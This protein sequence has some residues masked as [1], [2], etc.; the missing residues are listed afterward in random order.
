MS[1]GHR[2]DYGNAIMQKGGFCLGRTI[3]AISR[4]ASLESANK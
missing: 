1:T 4:Q 2:D 3:G